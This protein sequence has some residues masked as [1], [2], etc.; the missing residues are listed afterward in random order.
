M[1]TFTYNTRGQSVTI[2]VTPVKGQM[3]TRYQAV[4]LCP[5]CREE[6][7]YGFT[8]RIQKETEVKNSAKSGVNLH[9][10]RNHNLK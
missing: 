7:R 1:G 10:K 8:G 4:A 2:T 3:W 9:L 6:L 5:L